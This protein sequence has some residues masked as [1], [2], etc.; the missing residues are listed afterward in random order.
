MFIYRTGKL[1][2]CQIEECGNPKKKGLKSRRVVWSFVFQ[3]FFKSC[4][5]DF[6]LRIFNVKYIASYRMFIN[7]V[8]QRGEIGGLT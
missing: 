6:N 7:I 3:L 8:R 2:N 1:F 5:Q 4:Q